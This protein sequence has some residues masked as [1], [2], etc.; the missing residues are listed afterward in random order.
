MEIVVKFRESVAN[1]TLGLVSEAICSE[2]AR[3]LGLSTPEGYFVKIRP[4]MGEFIAE[5]DYAHVVNASVGINYGSSLVKMGSATFPFSL[6]IPHQAPEWTRE[7]FATDFMI[8]NF[9]RQESNHNLL[10]DGK[11]YFLIDH[12]QALG[13]I[14]Q[15]AALDLN[16][17]D[18]DPLYSHLFYIIGHGNRLV[19]FLHKI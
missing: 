7:V 11:D 13:R 9:D 12:E 1:N 5:R 4:H 14:Y 19:D 17:W 15:A 3:A 18:V 6:R 16:V 2:L 10:F 8:Q